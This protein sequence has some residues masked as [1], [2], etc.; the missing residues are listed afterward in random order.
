VEI[1]G[2]YKKKHYNKN[3]YFF[4]SCCFYYEL[5]SDFKNEFIVCKYYN[6]MIAVLRIIINLKLPTTMTQL[7]GEI[8]D[9][10]IVMITRDKARQNALSKFEEKYVNFLGA[11]LEE[12]TR[13]I[14][15]SKIDHGWLVIANPGQLETALGHDDFDFDKV[16]IGR[17]FEYGYSTP[18]ILGCVMADKPNRL[19]LKHRGIGTEAEI[20]EG[21]TS[22]PGF[23]TSDHSYSRSSI[24]Q[25]ERKINTVKSAS[26]TE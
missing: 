19:L 23:I 26:K 1:I 18:S 14:N 17:D 11:P 12:S 15:P 21:I 7:Y 13:H 24:Y 9:E 22:I 8:V 20:R 3:N 4:G 6:V 5:S 25:F 10:E 16:T 2:N